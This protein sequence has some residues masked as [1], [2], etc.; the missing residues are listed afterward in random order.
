MKTYVYVVAEMVD[1]LPSFRHAFIHA[2]DDD[3]AYT[4]GHRCVR[5]PT[6]NGIN[7][8]VIEIPVELSPLPYTTK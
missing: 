3:D 2:E 6:G 1:G 5:Q 7:D 4:V 8:Y